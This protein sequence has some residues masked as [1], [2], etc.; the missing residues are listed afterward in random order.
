MDQIC[1]CIYIPVRPTS[2]AQHP[3]PPADHM[4]I[5]DFCCSN[6]KALVS[7]VTSLEELAFMQT[8]L[9]VQE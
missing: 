5:S 1:V 8:Y 4:V 6:H 2:A 3:T 7:D 9:G